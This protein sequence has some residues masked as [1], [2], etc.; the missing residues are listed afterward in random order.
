M[1]DDIIMYFQIDG[2]QR[3]NCTAL[4]VSVDGRYLAT[5]GDRVIKIWDYSMRLDINFQVI[6]Q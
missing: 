4:D 2:V 3:S 5:A 1:V 6:L